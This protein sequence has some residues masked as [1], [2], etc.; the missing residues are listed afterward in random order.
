MSHFH[1]AVINH[2]TSCKSAIKRGAR[3]ETL[4]SQKRTQTNLSEK[5]LPGIYHAVYLFSHVVHTLILADKSKP[6]RSNSFRI[7]IEDSEVAAFLPNQLMKLACTNYPFAAFIE[8]PN[9]ML[10]FF[11]V[12]PLHRGPGKGNK[13]HH[14]MH[15][16]PSRIS[17]HRRFDK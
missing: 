17:V 4:R 10:S 6:D 5:N 3:G 1:Q 9:W 11:S 8:E 2:R 15:L 12:C 14:T 7:S 16:R 13:H